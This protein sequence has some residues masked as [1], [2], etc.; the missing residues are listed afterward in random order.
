MVDKLENADLVKSQ[1]FEI[2]ENSGDNIDIPDMIE[3]PM[4]DNP[5]DQSL[6]SN[7]MN[8]VDPD[9][10]FV[11]FPEQDP[12]ENPGPKMVK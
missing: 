12:A 7:R 9:K 10:D 2:E 8:L 5:A 6:Q 1:E 11:D 3:S 4:I